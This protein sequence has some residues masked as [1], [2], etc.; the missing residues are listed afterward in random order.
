MIKIILEIRI[1]AQQFY[2]KMVDHLAY[3]L[4]IFI[5]NYW[6]YH[7]NTIEDYDEEKLNPAEKLWTIVKYVNNQ[8]NFS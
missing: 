4:T 3:Q 7:K 5:E 8:G 2:K 1:H 6:I